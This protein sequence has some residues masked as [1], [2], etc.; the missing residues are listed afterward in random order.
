MNLPRILVIDDLFF[1]SKEDRRL[2][3]HRLG[4]A[5]LTDDQGGGFDGDYV[6]EAVFQPGQR[7]IGNEIINSTE[8]AVRA[9]ATGWNS[10]DRSALDRNWALVLL[11]LQFDE[12][13]VAD[14]P[15][16]PISN[17]PEQANRKF[18][19]EILESL[20]REWPD[21]DAATGNCDV[22][23]IMLSRVAKEE[24]SRSAG[25]AGARAY[26]EK[27][28][29]NKDLFEDILGEHGLVEDNSNLLVGRSLPLLKTLR[30]AREVARSSRGNLLVLGETGSGKTVLAEYIH[31]HSPRSG[32]ELQKFTVSEGYE[33]S[34]LN[35]E[36]FG[37]WYG[38]FTSADQ[39]EAGKGERA[40]RGTLLIDEIGNLPKP[41]QGLLLEYCRLHNDGRR[42]LKRLGNF[43]TRAEF[44]RQAN[45]SLIGDYNRQTQEISVDVFL[46]SAT[47]ARIDDPSYRKDTGFRDDLYYRLAEEY[48]K[49]IQ[50][51]SLRQRTDDIGVLFMH[52]LE[53]AT[54]ELGGVWPKE[55]NDGLISILKAYTWPGN[56]AQLKGAAREVAKNSKNWDEVNSRHLPILETSESNATM[57]PEETEKPTNQ[58]L[59]SLDEVVRVLDGAEVSRSRNGLHGK[60]FKV[61]DASARLM[62]RLLEAA[63]E[64]TKDQQGDLQPTS[65][66][67]RLLGKQDLPSTEAASYLLRLSKI[68]IEEPSESSN[69]GLAVLWAKKRRRAAKKKVETPP[70]SLH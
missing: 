38:A 45:E 14:G 67:K 21:P 65:A 13:T 20:A 10:N 32:N 55:V 4:L 57:Q 1:W 52:Y 42:K 5:D 43:P 29:L 70:D 3:C 49:P 7:R 18:G 62:I 15:V 36:L 16:D 22:P 60:L 51:P 64:E 68:F 35:S 31:K 39:S 28:D 69:V 40:N 41:S 61:Q 27:L 59:I 6:A 46:I 33:P 58:V 8:E 30:R 56:I 26:I 47:N 54:N 2:W 19:L 53:G 63:L 11:D 25:R 17:W 9:V 66:L 12:G 37:Y 50:F 23:I 44:V 48:E 34:G 24:A